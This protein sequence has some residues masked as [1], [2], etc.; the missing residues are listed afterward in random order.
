VKQATDA[1]VDVDEGMVL[2]EDVK[3]A[4]DV[5]SGEKA[6]KAKQGEG[7]EGGEGAAF[8]LAAVGRADRPARTKRKTYVANRVL[9]RCPSL[10]LSPLARGGRGP[11]PR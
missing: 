11:L 10:G 6:G 4:D 8:R 3:E 9:E 7:L 1:V 2:D 5:G